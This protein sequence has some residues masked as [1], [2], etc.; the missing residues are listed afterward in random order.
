MTNLHR[1]LIHRIFFMLCAA[2]SLGGAGYAD[3]LKIGFTGPFTGPNAFLGD[4]VAHGL[5]LGIQHTNAAKTLDY[6]VSF[7]ALNDEYNPEKTTTTVNRL[8]HDFKVQA[9]VG[10]IGTPTA[11]A[12][13]PILERYD[14]PLIAPITGADILRTERASRHIFSF[15]TTYQEESFYLVKTLICNLDITGD[16][17]A[18]LAQKDAY[19]DAGVQ[20][21]MAALNHYGVKNADNVLLIRYLRNHTSASHA[22]ADIVSS[23]PT[24][25]VVFLVSTSA[26]SA[27]LIKNLDEVGISPLFAALSFSGLESLATFTQTTRATTLVSQVTPPLTETSLPL[28]KEFLEDYERYSQDASAPTTLE[29]D[30]YISAR[31][32]GYI[33]SKYHP[34]TPPT[35]TEII[36]TLKN[37]DEFDLGLETMLSLSRKINSDTLPPPKIWL[38]A[39]LDGEAVSVSNNQQASIPIEAIPFSVGAQNE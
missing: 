10:S 16:E 18:I 9:L 32:F 36:T 8:I 38:S 17:I 7:I 35:S 6:D 31:F 34:N 20:G 22:A 25:K 24:P 19:G 26:T 4:S 27:Q 30:G 14:I 3:S 21:L 5:R 11:I 13:L 1:R 2:F 28:I 37:L 29:L 33:L 23:F 12:S 39:V 15:R